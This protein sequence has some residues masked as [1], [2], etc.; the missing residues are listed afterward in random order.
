MVGIVFILNFYLTTNT[1]FRNSFVILFISITS[2]STYENPELKSTDSQ[3]R[4]RSPAHTHRSIHLA[5]N[6]RMASTTANKRLLLDHR[7]HNQHK[8]TVLVILL[9]GPVPVGVLSA[10][11]PRSTS[12]LFS[13][14]TSNLR[15]TLCTSISKASNHSHSQSCFSDIVSIETPSPLTMVFHRGRSCDTGKIILKTAG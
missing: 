13:T 1:Q 7:H 14:S 2:T 5:N 15:S 6:A 3:T 10:P 11:L 9:L 4:L 12:L 8:R